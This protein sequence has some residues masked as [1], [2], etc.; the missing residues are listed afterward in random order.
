MNNML[1]AKMKLG[2]RTMPAFAKTPETRA[3]VVTRSHTGDH[4]AR[5]QPVGD[6][7]RL[8]DTFQDAYF[9]VSVM[10]ASKPAK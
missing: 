4:H 3:I 7:F 5:L 9:N 2:A 6:A 1:G 10:D 8:L